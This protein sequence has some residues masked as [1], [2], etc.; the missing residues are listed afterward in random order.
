MSAAVGNRT[1][2][3]PSWLDLPVQSMTIRHAHDHTPHL[4]LIV[5]ANCSLHVH[6]YFSSNS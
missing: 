2:D 5:T 1:Q 6:H 3:T 4:A